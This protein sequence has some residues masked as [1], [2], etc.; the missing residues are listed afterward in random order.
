MALDADADPPRAFTRFQFGFGRSLAEFVA[1]KVKGLP[2]RVALRKN[3]GH[4][5]SQK[6]SGRRA[7]E[8]LGRRTKPSRP[9]HRA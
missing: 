7:E 1:F 8:F 3:V 6:M 5:F 4:T 2:Q 9:A